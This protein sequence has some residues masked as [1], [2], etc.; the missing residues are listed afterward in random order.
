[1]TICR[2]KINGTSTNTQ[3]SLFWS[4]ILLSEHTTVP[5]SLN[6][7]I[8]IELTY[9]KPHIQK[10]YNFT[11]FVADHSLKTIGPVKNMNLSLTPQSFLLP[12]P[13]PCLLPFSMLP[14]HVSRQVICFP[15]LY[16]CHHFFRNLCKHICT[17]SPLWF[18]EEATVLCERMTYSFVLQNHISLYRST[19]VKFTH[20]ALSG[21]MC[22]CF[23][24]LKLKLVWMSHKRH[25]R[26]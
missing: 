13:V 4:V 19:T 26:T 12:L 17:S 10:E 18:Q 2:I 24:L 23:Q 7:Y 15:S 6:M 9:Q 16:M 1:M 20:T 21:W 5:N 11:S 8:W 25:C 22:Y 3:D 14:I